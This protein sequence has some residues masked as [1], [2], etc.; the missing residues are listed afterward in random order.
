VA[1]SA[2][3]GSDDTAGQQPP[4]GGPPWE[5]RVHGVAGT[6]PEQ[7]LE[8]T[9]VELPTGMPRGLEL[10]RA[11]QVP[12]HRRAF[13]WGAL[14]S[15][16]P[17][18]AFNVL[19]LPYMLANVAGWMLPTLA[20]PVGVLPSA[21][22]GSD[23]SPAPLVRAVVLVV[24]LNGLVV[25][26][27]FALFVALAFL[28]VLPALLATLLGDGWSAVLGYFGGVVTLL[29][30]GGFTKVRPRDATARL[31]GED[32]VPVVDRVGA[33]WFDRDQDRLWATPQTAAHLHRA[34]VCAAIAIV[35]AVAD[36]TGLESVSS[37]RAGST[38]ASLVAAAAVLVLAT[39]ATGV[40]TLRAGRRLPQPWSRL[41]RTWLPV[42][43]AV[44]VAGG[45]AGA[46]AL[47]IEPT[48]QLPVVPAA[49]TLVGAASLVLTVLL[50]FVVC[51]TR[52]VGTTVRQA[53]NGPWVLL[54][55]AAVGTVFG[56]G[57]L[58]SLLRLVGRFVFEDPV[59]EQA[60]EQVLRSLPSSLEWVALAFTVVAVV[61]LLLGVH[62]FVRASRGV[63]AAIPARWMVTLRA[64]VTPTS[65]W[66][67]TIG[68]SGALALVALLVAGFRCADPTRG[69]TWPATELQPLADPGCLA[70]VT[71]D[72]I[73]AWLTGL[74][75][76]AVAYAVIGLTAGGF[77]RFGV[78][79]ALGLLSLAVLIRGVAQ[80]AGWQLG[81]L[82]AFE[83]PVSLPTVV[84]SVAFV[85][86]VSLLV[87]RLAL[88]G[89]RDRQTRRGL[90]VLWDVATFWPRWFHPF[91]QRSYSD[92]AV[93]R[94]SALL[95]E[96]A[97]VTPGPPGGTP[98][99]P[100]VL[101]P[102]SQGSV[103]AVPAIL[104]A[105]QAQPTP[106]LSS[107]ALLT[108]GSPLGTLYREAF[109]A[110]FPPS[111]TTT[112]AQLLSPA[113][114]EATPATAPRW[115]NLWRRSDPIGGAIWRPDDEGRIPAVDALSQEPGD[116]S[117]LGIADT[118]VP[119]R[120]HSNYFSEPAYP[121]A[122]AEL[123]AEVLPGPPPEEPE[124][125][126]PKPASPT[127]VGPPL[128]G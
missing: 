121:Q 81:W 41:V 91:A 114:D 2:A 44:A 108:Y 40:L 22:D 68:V 18:H 100:T 31:W 54:L 113:G 34:H 66:V 122:L 96:R 30:L 69:G 72:A 67:T 14:T 88:G 21:P 97:S 33:A 77:V 109:P 79:G 11:R 89:M 115:R 63:D 71:D 50:G 23:S 124:T 16:E 123:W 87:G 105:A 19:L 117:A 58:T 51:C 47:P 56:A 95:Q 7:L 78:G 59:R 46:P 8:A 65:T 6:P 48:A 35:V 38:V 62:A 110:M 80:V 55:A 45:V 53:W 112:V 126:E 127:P 118:W 39:V 74:L 102:H 60:Q 52:P 5:L 111:L 13:S 128:G 94:L 101:A 32:G 10:H 25:T 9:A 84:T 20:K 103:L 73:L 24:R 36:R 17:R 93:S 70:P 120:N 116:A 4:G 106:D 43:T 92:T 1:T 107:L 125:P 26:A 90:A 82:T 85:F 83:P 104:H 27:I 86:P 42:L 28:R 29:S 15:G 76:L 3:E 75:L 61:L 57:L 64:V 99:G 98:P 119:S 12:Q 37:W 49:L